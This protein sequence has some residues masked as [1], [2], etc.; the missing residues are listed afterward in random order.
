MYSRSGERAPRYVTM[1]R[2]N[3]KQLTKN[4]PTPIK[5]PG[6]GVRTPKALAPNYIT[7]N[8]SVGLHGAYGDSAKT[9]TVANAFNAFSRDHTPLPR[10]IGDYSVVRTTAL[11]NTAHTTIL[12]GP[13]LEMSTATV[14]G[15]KWRAILAMSGVAGGTAI[16][17]ASNAYNWAAPPLNKAAW[18]ECTLVPSALS[19]Q[20]MN[21][22]AL[23]TT[24]GIC[25][26]GRCKSIPV[27]GGSSVTWDAL[28]GELI[29][30]G[31]PT[32][33]SAGKLAMSG[34]QVDAVPMDMS[35]LSAFK[36]RVTH[37]DGAITW[38]D[39]VEQF[40]GFAPIFVHNPNG[41]ALQYLVSCEWRVRFDPSE[42]AYATHRH[43]APA[44]LGF[45]DRALAYATDIGSGVLDIT[46]A[47]AKT[48]A[49]AY[50][51]QALMSNF[52]GGGN[53]QRAIEL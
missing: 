5:N 23:Q 18:N 44:S 36:Q 13:M 3:K 49:V 15:P 29:N 53:R 33:T 28:A 19:V 42:P 24:T 14:D 47:R 43:H 30:Y 34:V 32:L 10:A 1:T 38:G 17:G 48:E 20:V 2:K 41:V 39:Q 6:R 12:F 31:S 27:L 50:A 26:I 52:R 9:P 22:E 35:T 45:W 51:R 11:I 25:Y 4:G 40:A 37:S 46:A 16:S 8:V 7:Q 21:P